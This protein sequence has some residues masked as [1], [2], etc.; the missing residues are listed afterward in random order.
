MSLLSRDYNGV[1]LDLIP[2]TEQTVGGTIAFDM[3]GHTM[4]VGG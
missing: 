1:A 2:Q 3:I 4:S